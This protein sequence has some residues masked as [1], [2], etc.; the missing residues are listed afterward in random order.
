VGINVLYSGTVSAATEGAIL[1]VPSIAVSLGTH[2]READFGF[3]ARFARKAAQFMLHHNPNRH[4]PL[5]VNVPAI[6]EKDIKGVVVTRQGQARLMEQFEKRI[7]PRENVYYWLAGETQVEE[8]EDA[9]TDFV[10]L[11]S[12]MISITPIYYD[13]TRYDALEGLRATIEKLTP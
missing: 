7:D 9:G 6:P 3:A 13:M 8:T 12:G 1:G 5:N 11:R 10:A 4:I 2:S